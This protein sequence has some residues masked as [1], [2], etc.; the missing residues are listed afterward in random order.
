[1]QRVLLVSLHAC[2]V[3]LHEVVSLWSESL[4]GRCDVAGLLALNK[5]LLSEIASFFAARKFRVTAIV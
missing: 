4:F 2:V 5:P 1:M 3:V